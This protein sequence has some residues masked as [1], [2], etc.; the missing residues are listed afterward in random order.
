MY[1]V[2][3]MALG[4]TEKR[5]EFVIQCG[6]RPSDWIDLD[7]WRKTHRTYE[8]FDLEEIKS[9]KHRSK[10]E[11]WELREIERILAHEH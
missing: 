6:K 1:G 11:E 9:K 10:H 8:Y 4:S 3:A 7:G 2:I 5:E